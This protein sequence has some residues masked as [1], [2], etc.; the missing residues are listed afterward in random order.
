MEKEEKGYSYLLEVDGGINRDTYKEALLKGS[1][2]LVVGSA[3]FKDDDPVD[4]VQ[5]FKKA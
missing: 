1:E 3:F 2:V 5:R 4:L